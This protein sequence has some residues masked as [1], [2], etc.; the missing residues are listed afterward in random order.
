M[1]IAHPLRSSSAFAPPMVVSSRPG[2]PD[3]FGILQGMSEQ[4]YT[5]GV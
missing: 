1:V 5:Y 2:D 3:S 4:E